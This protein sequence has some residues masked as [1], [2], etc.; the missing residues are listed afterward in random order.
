[1]GVF[2]S[3][4]GMHPPEG[5]PICTALNGRPE[6]VPP[7]ISLTT[8]LMVIPMGTSTS[9]PRLT[10]PARAKTFVPVEAAVPYALKA[11]APFR[12]IHGTLANV[13]TLLMQVGWPHSPDSTG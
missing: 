8:S 7:P 5:P 2:P 6:I 9:P 12:M 13:S 3:Q 1:M 11:S 10:F 4:A